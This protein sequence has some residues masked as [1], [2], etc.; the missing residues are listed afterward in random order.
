MLHSNKTRKRGTL[1][2]TDKVR[3]FMQNNL[4]TFNGNQALGDDDNF[5]ELGFVDSSFAMQLVLFVEEE[6][7]IIVTDEDL[8]LINFSTINRVA[9]FVERKTSN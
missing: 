9:Q 2:I 8:D 7:K 6:F 4:M 1:S 5:F 3:N